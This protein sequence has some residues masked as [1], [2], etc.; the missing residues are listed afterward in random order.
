MGIN[1]EQLRNYI[2][3]PTLREFGMWSQ[4]AE[5]LVMGTAAQESLLGTYLKQLAGGPALG[6]YQM[7]PRSFRDIFDNYIVYKQPLAK[8]MCIRFG[9]TD[10]LHLSHAAERLVYDMRFATLMARLQYY[11]QSERLPEA[12]DIEGLARYWKKYYNT[13]LGKGKVEEFIHNYKLT[14]IRQ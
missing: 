13:R 11:R 6:I 3:M 12:N 1:A 4:T 7:E 5:N 14:L 10:T 8:K 9:T 2:V